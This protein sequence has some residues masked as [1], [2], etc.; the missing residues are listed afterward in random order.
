MKETELEFKTST[1]P[2]GSQSGDN[3]LRPLELEIYKREYAKLIWVVL[4]ITSLSLKDTFLLESI[5][6]SGVG[7]VDG[8]CTLK[9]TSTKAHQLE[10]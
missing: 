7:G 6:A 8:V 4:N 1:G 3:H 5:G 2:S 10:T 9:K